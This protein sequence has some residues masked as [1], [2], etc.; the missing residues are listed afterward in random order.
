[1][2]GAGGMGEVYRAHDSELDRQV[3]KEATSFRAG[4]A[5]VLALQLAEDWRR[6]LVELDGLE[7]R[8]EGGG[9]PTIAAAAVA[10]ERGL[11][12]AKTGDR[13][14]AA[15]AL[16]RLGAMEAERLLGETA[17]Q[18]A[19]IAAAL[20]DA[21]RSVSWLRQAFAEG[22]GLEISVHY[23]PAFA[24]LR[25]DLAYRELMDPKD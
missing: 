10:G 7:S 6:C 4:L 23:D 22:R 8:L 5:L 2:L 11:V 17:Y 21:E 15:S 25:S 3:A 18:R 24:A 12:A 14:R 16:E 13:Q 1:M 19:R 20:G 9:E